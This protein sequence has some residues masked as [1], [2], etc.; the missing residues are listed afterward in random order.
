MHAIRGTRAFDG[1]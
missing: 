1:A